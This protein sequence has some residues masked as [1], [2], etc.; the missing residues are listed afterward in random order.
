MTRPKQLLAAGGVLS[1]GAAV[2]ISGPTAPSVGAA[3]ASPSDAVRWRPCPQYSDEA[4]DTLRVPSERIPQFRALLARLECG[5]VSVPLDYT[6]PN[7][8]PITVA[9]TRLK[10]TD[11]A[12]RL[13]SLAFNPGGPGGSGY[14]MPETLLLTG[15]NLASL[16]ER[17]DL[18]G[19]DPRGVGYSTKVN[20]PSPGGPPPSSGDPEPTLSDPP[21][22]P[23]GPAPGPLTEELARQFYADQTRV[24]ETCVRTDPDLLLQLTT[25]NVARDLNQI[26]AALHEPTISYFGVSW[27]T[28]LGAVYRSMFPATVSRMW[29]DSVVGP[30]GARLDV[31]AA[32]TAKATEQNAARLAAWIADRNATYGLGSTPAQVRATLL[33]IKRNLDANPVKFSDVP[34]PADGNLVA[35]LARSVSPLWTEASQALKELVGATSGT[36]APPPLNSIQ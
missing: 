35:F 12:H 36:P 18:I 9:F 15:S 20:C 11:K 25:A 16:N 21:P 1:I 27:G 32:D 34:T 24:N 26:R 8:R 2:L 23:G 29:L 13:G 28:L 4:I 33:A 5:T 10:A 17:Y 30:T 22:D 6:R 31:R 3:G 14:L 19:F 7:G